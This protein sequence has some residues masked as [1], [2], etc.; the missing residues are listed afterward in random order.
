MEE[1]TQEQVEDLWKDL[2][3]GVEELRLDLKGIRRGL[4]HLR[5]LDTTIR[6]INAAIGMMMQQVKGGKRKIF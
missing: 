1:L 3:D 6:E 2:L 5:S 4:R